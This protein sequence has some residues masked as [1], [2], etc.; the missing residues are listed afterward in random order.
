[1]G[2]YYNGM[3]DIYSDPTQHSAF[4][5]C[6]MEHVE[7]TEVK[8]F[9]ETTTEAEIDAKVAQIYDEFEVMP[10]CSAGRSSAGG[11]HRLRAG[12]AGQQA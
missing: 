2:H 11:A 1:M 12:Q 8:Y 6:H 4:F 3:L 5:G 9:R 10:D 7:I